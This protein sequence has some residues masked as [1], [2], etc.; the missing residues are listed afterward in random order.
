MNLDVINSY[1]VNTLYEFLDMHDIVEQYLLDKFKIIN[2]E[3]MICYVQDSINEEV[4]KSLTKEEIVKFFIK[5]ENS[6]MCKQLVNNISDDGDLYNKI[7]YSFKFIDK[8][9]VLI[10]SISSDE[11]EEGYTILE[12]SLSSYL[13]KDTIKLLST[14]ITQNQISLEE[15]QQHLFDTHI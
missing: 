10:F 12:C 1:S 11:W 4:N 2:H 6:S 14:I 9:D 7:Q 15:I 5:K 8:P 3:T 13:K